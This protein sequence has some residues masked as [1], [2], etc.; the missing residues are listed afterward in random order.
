MLVSLSVHTTSSEQ[1]TLD[2]VCKNVGGDASIVNLLHVSVLLRLQNA[3]NLL[4]CCEYMQVRSYEIRDHEGNTYHTRGLHT[5]HSDR[6]KLRKIG[7]R[8][9]CR[10]CVRV[11]GLETSED[12]SQQLY[13]HT[14]TM[15][16]NTF[17][18]D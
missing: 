2:Q 4:S 10:Y 12:L 3:Y 13:S 6:Q 1:L 9:R 14:A 8:T 11:S 15:T 18:H 7:M 17:I 16:V 5:G